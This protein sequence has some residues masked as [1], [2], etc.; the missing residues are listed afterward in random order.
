MTTRR[1]PSGKLYRVKTDRHR[2][3]V[4]HLRD[5]L[6][7]MSKE[8]DAKFVAEY[9]APATVTLEQVSAAL[10]DLVKDGTLRIVRKAKPGRYGQGAVYMRNG[11]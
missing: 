7:H 4:P 2:W 11:K 5:E 6:E 10:R 8:F 9:V 3:L 1:S